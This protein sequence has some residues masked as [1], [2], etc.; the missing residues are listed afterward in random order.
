ME[1]YEL[2]EYGDNLSFELMKCKTEKTH[3]IAIEIMKT[4]G[5]IDNASKRGEGFGTRLYKKLSD[6]IKVGE[7]ILKNE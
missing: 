7:E 4:L 6:L 3:K 5:S 1:R 2:Y